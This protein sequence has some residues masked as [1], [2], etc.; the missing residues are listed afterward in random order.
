M[1]SFRIKQN[2]SLEE[3]IDEILAAKAPITQDRFKANHEERTVITAF[4][5]A[6]FSDNFSISRSGVSYTDVVPQ[7][8]IHEAANVQATAVTAA[9][10]A[11]AEDSESATRWPDVPI[12]GDI[13]NMS[14][15]R[16]PSWYNRMKLM[17]EHG[18]HISLAGPPGIGKSSAVEYL[19]AEVGKPLVNV[20]ADAGLRRRDLTGN[21]ELVNAHTRFMV[22][23]YVA[24]AVNGWWVKVDEVNA[25]DPDALMF[26]NSQ[27]AP[28]YRV[29]FYGRSLPV[30][31]D[32]RLFTTYNPGLVGTKP[33]PDSLKD[34]F[35]P[36]KLEFPNENQLRRMLEANGMPEP[37]DL[38]QR[39][40][41]AIVKFGIEAWS[42]H[43]RGRCRYQITPRRLMDAVLLVTVADENVFDALEQAVIAT[44]DNTAEA[45]LLKT[46]LKSVKDSFTFGRN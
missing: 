37:D 34:R 15:F 38:Q 24:A 23:E 9:R 20:S 46:T 4:K 19:A 6:A 35:F 39:W 32:F 3:L 10:S 16:K 12:V 30:H 17:V 7:T 42:Q 13:G 8:I 44:V 18:K 41:D 2:S 14:W 1:Y 26:L 45:A 25:A 28:P 29:N 11:G 5:L 22:A 33:L 36:I 43:K 40:Q 21:V 31:P 27:I